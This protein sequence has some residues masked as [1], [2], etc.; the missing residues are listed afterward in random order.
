MLN[1]EKSLRGEKSSEA[2]FSVT[3]NPFAKHPCGAPRGRGEQ[4]LEW[5]PLRV[6]HARDVVI[7]DDEKVGGRAEL[8]ARVGEEAPVHVTVRRDDGK[9]RDDLI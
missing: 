4:R 8:R 1:R 7:R 9:L 5:N 3:L 6:Q 2:S